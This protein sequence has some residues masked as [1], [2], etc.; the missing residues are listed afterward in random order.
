MQVLYT[1]YQVLV[2]VIRSIATN[3]LLNCISEAFGVTRSQRYL[4]YILQFRWY[5][6][7][8]HVR[9]LSW[10]HAVLMAKRKNTVIVLKDQIT[11]VAIS[12]LEA[13]N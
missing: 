1:E 13:L 6:G 4:T 5:Q 3:S 10:I 8:V 7:E 12:T 11:R 2:L 9:N